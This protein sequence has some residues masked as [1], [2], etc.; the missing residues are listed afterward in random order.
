LAILGGLY[1][2]RVRG[3]AARGGL[4][5]YTSLLGDAFSY[6]SEDIIVPGI[7]DSGDIPDVAGALAP[8]RLLLESLVDGRNRI[9]PETEFRPALAPAFE[10]YRN[11]PE[12]LRVRAGAETPDL[13]AWLAERL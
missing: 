13:C 7:L 5:G 8:R 6:V 11:T 12:R 1:E 9:V 2:D 3:V 4:A 10:S